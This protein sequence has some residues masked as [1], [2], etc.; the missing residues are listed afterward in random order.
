MARTMTKTTTAKVATKAETPAVV[1]EPKTDNI[2]NE[3]LLQIIQGLQA[4]IDGYEGKKSD[5]KIIAYS[6]MDAPCTVI[7]MVECVPTLD[8]TIYVNGQSYNFAKFGEQKQFPR[9]EM[10]Q[11]ISKHRR[12]FETGRLM[13]GEDCEEFAE[14]WGV[15]M[16][17]HPMTVQQYNQ[18]ANLPDVEFESLVKAMNQFEKAYLAETWVKRYERKEPGYG[19]I[20]KVKII[21]DAT[22]GLLETF[23][24]E[25]ATSK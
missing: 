4:K 18:M 19:N 15:P 12:L 10:Q 14:S 17:K 20:T 9:R 8:T 24:S 6:P 13:L 5:N 23:I 11:L 25:V 7:H 22:D 16:R 2:T 21:N 1:E 3:Q